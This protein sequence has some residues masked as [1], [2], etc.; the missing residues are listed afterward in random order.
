MPATCSERRS[1]A[2]SSQ[3]SAR[4]TLWLDAASFAVAAGLVAAAV[5][6]VRAVS[7]RKRYVDEL[8]E[9]LRFVNRDVVLRT[10]LAT[11]TVGNFLIAPLAPVLLPVYARDELGGATD[12]GLLVGAYGAGGLAGAVAFGLAGPRVP[13]R[14][15]FVVVWAAYPPAWAALVTLPGLAPAAVI[16]FLV[17]LVA[18]A[19]GPLEQ[20]VRQERTPAE[21]R[22][23][24]FATFMVSLTLVVP[25]ATLAAALLVDAAGLR[26]TVAVLAVTNTALTVWVLAG[27]AR[28]SL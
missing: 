25:P 27:R 1:R 23:R 4:R 8:L 18:G 22:S 9:G 7:E 2:S 12:L 11:A 5:P 19:L 16:L 20:L 3:R 24:V 26:A 14:P 28:K 21:L 6:T 15:L 13:R 10:F 17:G